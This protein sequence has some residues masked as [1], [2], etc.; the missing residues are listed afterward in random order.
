MEYHNGNQFTTKD[1]DNDHN[2]GKNCANLLSGGWWFHS[3]DSCNLN[4]LYNDSTDK[5]ITWWKW[6]LLRKSPSGTRMMVKP[7]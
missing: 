6:N 7:K 4:G 5:Q 3:C 2:S 1:R